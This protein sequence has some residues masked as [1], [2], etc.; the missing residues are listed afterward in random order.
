MNAT[1][2]LVLFFW[3][4]NGSRTKER[5][6]VNWPFFPALNVNTD[7]NGNECDV[8]IANVDKIVGGCCSGGD[9]GGVYVS[10]C[11]LSNFTIHKLYQKLVYL[12]IL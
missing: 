2:V 12:L 6:V 3:Y 4:S 5:K 1:F 10:M 11:P 7:L 8:K 9:G